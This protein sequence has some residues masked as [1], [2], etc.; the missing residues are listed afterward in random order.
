[1][2]VPMH[3]NILISLVGVYKK[4]SLTWEVETTWVCRKL[5]PNYRRKKE[6]LYIDYGAAFNCLSWLSSIFIASEITSCSLS[7]KIWL[8][9]LDRS[10]FKFFIHY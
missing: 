6:K 1:M 5:W 8:M 10:Y 2:Y 3:L 4:E 7:S 9:K